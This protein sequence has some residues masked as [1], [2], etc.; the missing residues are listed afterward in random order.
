MSTVKQNRKLD[1]IPELLYE[2]PNYPGEKVSPIPYIEIPKDKDMPSG[3]FVMEYRKTGEQEVG[4]SGKPEEIMDG[5]YPHMYVDFK[6][7]EAVLLESFPEIDIVSAVDKIRVG[8]GLKPL[9]KA[10]KEGNELLDRVVAR[11]NDIAATVFEKQK[12]RTADIAKSVVQEG[13]QS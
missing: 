13:E 9:V 11:A 6:H 2:A 8:L 12:E 3:L 10:R 7:V 1:Y 4:D 5:P